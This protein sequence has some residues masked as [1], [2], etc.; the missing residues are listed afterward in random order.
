MDEVYNRD[1][2]K[3]IECNSDITDA[4]DMGCGVEVGQDEAARK[5]VDYYKNL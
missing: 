2:L 4:K 3:S 1:C 5:T